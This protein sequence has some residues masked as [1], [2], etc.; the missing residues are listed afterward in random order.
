A[1]L[2]LVLALGE[3]RDRRHPLALLEIDQ[4]YALRVPSDHAD[5]V[6]PQ[7]HDLAAARDEH[8]LIGVRYHADADHAT[9]LLG[10]LHGDDALAAAVRSPVLVHLRPLAV[11]V[12]GDGEER[13]AGLDQV[14]RDDLIALVERHAAYAVGRAAHRADLGLFEPDGLAICGRQDDLALA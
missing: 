11:A 3:P 9:R 1:V 6:H 10:S 12:V 7:A 8:D 4:P 2:A 5:L 13:R 14:D